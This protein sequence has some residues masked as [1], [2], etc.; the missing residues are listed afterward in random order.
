M[1]STE[2]SVTRVPL[3]QP[4]LTRP[5]ANLKRA[6]TQGD[7]RS[8]ERLTAALVGSLLGVRLAV[9]DSGFQFGADAGTAG[10]QDRH[11][12]IES[13]RYSENTSLSKRELQGE[14]DDALSRNPDLELWILVCTRP[15]DEGLRETPNQKADD[16][17]LPIIIID[18]DE[19]SG[20]VPELAVL[21]AESPELVEQ[22][23]GKSAA[24]A[25]RAIR[26][27]VQPG[28][29]AIRRELEAWRIGY[30]SL[31]QAA[32]KRI[33]SIWKNAAQLT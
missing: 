18:R 8:L 25:A 27:V 11:V 1:P 19:R 26:E 10:S 4:A 3:N 31:R 9:S 14:V 30:E 6:L 23:Y 12:R 21:C 13:K 28:I 16:E 17:G 2:K 5:L 22:H 32:A 15:A 7:A 24:A 33:Q 29:E 20:T